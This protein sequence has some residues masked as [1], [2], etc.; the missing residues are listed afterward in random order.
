MSNFEP[1]SRRIAETAMKAANPKLVKEYVTVIEFLA[2]SPESAAALKG[3]KPPVIGSAAYIQKHAIGF[4]ESRLP[5]GPKAP[6]TVPDEMVSYILEHYFKVARGQL[7]DIKHTH[8]LSMG[9]ENLVGDLLERYLASVMEKHGWV[10]CSGAMVKAVDFVKAPSK[11][12]AEWLLLQVKNR[13]NSENS[14][15]SAIRNGT[16][17]LKWHRTFSKKQGSNWS[18]FP[19]ENVAGELSENGFRAF[20]GKYLKAL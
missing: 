13:D 1:N 20:V 8:K 10:W 2:M 9:A 19:D 18:K 16:A 14:S 7:E 11:A 6:E 3:K 4:C 17:I 12:S 5:R 15:S